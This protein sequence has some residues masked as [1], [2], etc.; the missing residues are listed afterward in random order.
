[1]FYFPHTFGSIDKAKRIYKYHRLSGYLVWSLILVNCILGTQ[2]TWFLGVWDNTWVWVV[3]GVV[4]FMGVVS[5]VRLSKMK[6][7]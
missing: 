7:L 4:A 2:S 6:F 1:M 3:F 5:R